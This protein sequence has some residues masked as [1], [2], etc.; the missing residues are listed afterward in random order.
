[1]INFTSFEQYFSLLKRVFCFYSEIRRVVREVE[2]AA[3]EMLCTE[4]Y[5]GFESLT[6]RHAKPLFC[7][8][9]KRGASQLYSPAASFIALQLYSSDAE[10]NCAARS[11]Y[12]LGIFT[13]RKNVFCLSRQ[14]AFLLIY[15][16]NSPN[17]Q[18]PLGHSVGYCLK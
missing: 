15:S 18:R 9:D 10:L 11:R 17:K 13:H 3:L 14:K 6:L 4:M 5:L 2:G 1:M 16:F 12:H 8:P 7:P